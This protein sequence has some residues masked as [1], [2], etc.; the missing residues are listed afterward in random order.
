MLDTCVLLDLATKKNNIPIVSALEDL[1]ESE[2]V[3]LIL[4]NLVM[5][6]FDK[7]KD[8]VADKTRIRLSQEFKQVKHIIQQFGGDNTAQTIDVLN[9]IDSRLPLLTDANYGTI[10]RIEGLMAGAI[11]LEASNSVNALAVQRGL[12]K[13]APFHRSKNSIA[14]AVIMEQFSEFISTNQSESNFFSFITHNI[15]DFSYSK[16]HRRPH[17]DFQEIFDHKNTSYFNDTASAIKVIDDEILKHYQFEHDYVE[18]TRGLDE[19]LDVMDELTNKV[20]YNR[21]CNRSYG[22]ENG[23]IRIIPDGTEEYGN[24]VIH[25]SIWEGAKKSAERVKEKY[26]DTGPWDD[27]EWGMINGKLSALR[28]IL[29]DDWDMLDT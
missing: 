29:G 11:N 6:E 1:V 24:D 17:E 10:S 18:E 3:K 13:Q 14:D 22:V 27:F 19:I 28:W 9:D 15:H 26:D 4:P 21:H 2:K 5:H 8:A 23:D 25:E 20:W 16:D 7:N 12:N